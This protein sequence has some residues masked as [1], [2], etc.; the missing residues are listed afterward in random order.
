MEIK[1][2]CIIVEKV[3]IILSISIIFKIIG[4]IITPYGK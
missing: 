1:E 4:R 2:L 3:T